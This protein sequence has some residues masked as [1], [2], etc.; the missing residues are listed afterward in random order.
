MGSPLNEGKVR[1]EVDK[2]DLKN[3]HCINTS[4]RLGIRGVDNTI[5]ILQILIS[6]QENLISTCI[7]KLGCCILSFVSRM[8]LA[9]LFTL[10]D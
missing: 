3:V 7:A 2:F 10:S 4:K 9:Y 5:I 6:I 8:A 1:L